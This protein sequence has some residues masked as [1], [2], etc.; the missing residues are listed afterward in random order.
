MSQEKKPRP[1]FLKRF[2]EI[3]VDTVNGFIQDDCYSKASALTFYSLL[4]IVPVLAVLFGIAKGFGFEKALE[5]EINDRFPEQHDVV[6]KLIE[7]AYSM[8]NNVK[9]G[10][11]A[12]IGIITLLWSV[13]GL[14]NNVETVLNSIWKTSIPRPYSRKIS[15]YV[16]TM[17]I[18]P[19]FLITSS[20]ITVYISTRIAE[21]SQKNS[22]VEVVGPFILFLINLFP[23]F[24]IWVLFILIYLFLPNTKVYFRSALI[25]GIV[26]G[27]AFQ[28]WQ[29]VYIKFQIGVSSYGAV[30]GSFAALPLFLIWMQ[31]SWLI[32]LA[33]AEL[34]FSIENDMFI[35]SRQMTPLSEKAIG[36]LISYRSVEAFANGK[37]PLTDRIFAH[38]LGLSLSQLHKVLDALRKEGI[39]SSVLYEDKTVGYQPSR[40]LELITMKAVCDAIDKN[41][42]MMASAD[43]SMELQNIQRYLS[44]MEDILCA[45]SHSLPLYQL[46]LY[47]D[48]EK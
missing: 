45:N 48:D 27:T 26:A 43:N 31:I 33:G 16:A 6:N 13:L 42:M 30:Y 23:F 14:L 37:P 21:E 38:E 40:S 47:E 41:H 19:I 39:L 7:F 10:V 29:W 34:A 35:P 32:L 28:L 24:L 17:I 2:F 9:G 12:G 1:F 15:D 46:P 11:I 36:L 18:G 22:L 4:S 8:L 3:I 25:G 20:S 44:K 5:F